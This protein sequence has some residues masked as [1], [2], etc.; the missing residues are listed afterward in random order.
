MSAA[1]L[2]FESQA[3]FLLISNLANKLNLETKILS[4]SDFEKDIF[5]SANESA[6]SE[7]LTSEEDD[8]WKNL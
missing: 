5:K 8:A 7:W 6:L 3:D 2:Y 1:A 4:D